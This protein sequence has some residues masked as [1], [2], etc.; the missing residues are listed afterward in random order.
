MLNKEQHTKTVFCLLEESQCLS[1]QLA[2]YCSHSIISI[3]NTT[4][5]FFIENEES[6]KQASVWFTDG[7]S[8]ATDGSKNYTLK[9]SHA[10]N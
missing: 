8:M 10:N 7:L 1:T 3:N 6:Q 4:P 5:F 2:G 9:R